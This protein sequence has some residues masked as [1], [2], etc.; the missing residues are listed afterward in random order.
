MQKHS[1]HNKRRNKK[2]IIKTAKTKKKK[3]NQKTKKAKTIKSKEIIKK[4]VKMTKTHQMAN[5]TNK[6][7]P[8]KKETRKNKI[9]DKV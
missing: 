9:H 7:S 4:K 6:P 1:P 8:M 2:R 3:I 5:Q